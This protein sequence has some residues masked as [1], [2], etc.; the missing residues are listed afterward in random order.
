MLNV[1]IG[2][3]ASDMDLEC[4]ADDPADLE[5]LLTWGLYLGHSREDV[6]AK[7]IA[8]WQEE[9]AE[10]MVLLDEIKTDPP[11]SAFSDIERMFVRTVPR[12]QPGHAPEEMECWFRIEDRLI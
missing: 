10:E 9:L 2:R 3:R 12:D 11:S 5:T 1:W 7:M 6:L 8:E 4:L